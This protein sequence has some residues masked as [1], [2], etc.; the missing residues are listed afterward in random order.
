MNKTSIMLVL[1]CFEI[2]HMSFYI[3]YNWINFA[4]Q[5]DKPT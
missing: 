1:F 5:V 3:F 4:V 2:S